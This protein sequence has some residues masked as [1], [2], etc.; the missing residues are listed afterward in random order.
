MREA[1]GG[2]R[3][4]WT[5]GTS[6]NRGFPK[7]WNNQGLAQGKADKEGAGTRGGVTVM[8][9]KGAGTR[10]RATMMDKE[11]GMPNQVVSGADTTWGQINW[12]KQRRI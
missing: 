8:D 2:E 12:E 3:V 10:G 9:N 7:G 6:S 5:N 4:T 1:G 11:Q